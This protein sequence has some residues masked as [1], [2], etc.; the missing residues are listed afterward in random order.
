[1]NP[2]SSMRSRTSCHQ[3]RHWPVTPP[4]HPRV[5]RRRTRQEPPAAAADPRAP[6]GPGSSGRAF[7]PHGIRSRSAQSHVHA[8]RACTA[9]PVLLSPSPVRPWRGPALSQSCGE[10]G[11]AR[12]KQRVST[13]SQVHSPLPSVTALTRNPL[14][15]S[16]LHPSATFVTCPRLAGCRPQDQGS[17]GGR[18]THIKQCSTTT[19]EET[20]FTGADPAVQAVHGSNFAKHLEGL[21]A[22]F[23]VTRG[24]PSGRRPPPRGP[25]ACGS[26]CCLD[27]AGDPPA[28]RRPGAGRR[29]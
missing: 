28:R 6:D 17:G 2:A 3:S 24:R 9:S 5:C 4:A 14:P 29:P 27:G 21:H 26:G 19:Q 10:V 18:S 11:R 15:P 23:S 1:M 7:H 13:T 25:P 16:G 12:I 22:R 8:S 20:H